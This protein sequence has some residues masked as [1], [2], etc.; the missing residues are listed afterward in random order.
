MKK[1]KIECYHA[2]HSTQGKEYWPDLQSGWYV[3]CPKC[4]KWAIQLSK[5]DDDGWEIPTGEY[6][7]LEARAEPYDSLKTRSERRQPHP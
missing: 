2:W 7:L 6:I 5:L 1:T 3:F 4:E